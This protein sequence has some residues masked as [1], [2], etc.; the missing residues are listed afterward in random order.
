MSRDYHYIL[1]L[2]IPGYAPFTY[3]GICEPVPPV[4]SE[5]L[6]EYV[7][8]QALRAVGRPN[9]SQYSVLFWYVSPNLL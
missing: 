1:T 5:G 8:E 9:E 4:T 3:K 7:L 6:F 2:Q